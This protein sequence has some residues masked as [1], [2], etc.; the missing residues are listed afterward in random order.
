MAFDSLDVAIDAAHQ[1]GLRIYGDLPL[2]DMFFPGL[3]NDYFDAHPNLW[4]TSRDQQGQWRGLPCY[5]EPGA[6]DYRVAEVQELVERGVDG[7]SYYIASHAAGGHGRVPP[8]SF[9]FNAPIVA[10]YEKEHG[11]NILK[12]DFDPAQLHALNG[13]FF[14]DLLRRIRAVIGPNRRLVSEITTH[15]YMGYGGAGGRQIMARFMT[16]GPVTQP[17]AYRFDLEWQQWIDQGIADDLLVF[18]PLPNAVAEVRQAIRS[19]LKKG[20]VFLERETDQ[21]KYLDD[22]RSELAAIRGGALDGYAID[23]LKDYLDPASPF[24]ELLK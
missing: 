12:E 16:G 7:I 13:R 9:A 21:P 17:S 20:R 4:L 14:T 24:R 19:K 11:V 5:A 3:E 2:F 1:R 10:A 6:I 18:A 8:D 15:D 22:F 23:E